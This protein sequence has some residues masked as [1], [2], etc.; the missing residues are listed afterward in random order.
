MGRDI[1][2]GYPF[3]DVK[4]K[5]YRLIAREEQ[6]ELTRLCKE[7]EWQ[8]DATAALKE[9]LQIL[10]GAGYTTLHPV[11]RFWRDNRLTRIGEG[12]SEIQHLVISRELLKQY[13]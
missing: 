13:R 5:D 8:Y 2:T 12:S 3:E 6:V 11:E 9:A 7:G 4:R 1:K 10:G